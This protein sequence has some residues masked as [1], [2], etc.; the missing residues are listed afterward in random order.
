[1]AAGTIGLIFAHA[2]NNLFNDFTDYR[3]GVDKDNYFRT[4][5]GPQPLAPR[6]DDPP[7]SS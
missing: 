1:M 5:Y 7:R 6:A 4:Q 3:P 2:T